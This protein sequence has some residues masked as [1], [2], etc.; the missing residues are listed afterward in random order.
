[1][2]KVDATLPLLLFRVKNIQALVVMM[3]FYQTKTSISVTQSSQDIPSTNKTFLVQMVSK[4]HPLQI[5]IVVL[6]RRSARFTLLSI[7]YKV[8]ITQG[9][10][11]L[12]LILVHH[13][14]STSLFIDVGS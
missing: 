10:M 6:C 3:P 9:L 4:P 2:A 7:L 11:P 14:L 8:D 5:P 13:I 12:K 1:V